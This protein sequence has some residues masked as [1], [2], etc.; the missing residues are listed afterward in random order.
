[1]SNLMSRLQNLFARGSKQVAVESK[2][3]QRASRVVES[4]LENEQLTAGLD[5]A[6]ARPLIAWG[7]ACAKMI[8]HSSAGL[9]DAQAQQAMSPRLRA[10]RRL[11]RLVSRWFADRQEMDAAHSAAQ[12][13]MVIE[14]AA[15]IYDKAFVPPDKA[16]RD[17]FLRQSLNLDDPP[18]SIKNLRALFESSSYE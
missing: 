17:A 4:I 12:L 7:S 5:D 13:A 6:T 9:D 8:A 11:M 16:R 15:I 18:Q 2:L 10:T 3:A 14:Q 1:M